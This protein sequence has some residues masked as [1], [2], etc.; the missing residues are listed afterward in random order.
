MMVGLPGSGKSYYAE[1]LA[2]SLNYCKGELVRV[3]SR[4]EIRF[5][6]LKDDEN[7]FKHET[8][9]FNKY[10][11][12]IQASLNSAAINAVIADATHLNET[13]RN[14]LLNRLDLTNIEVVP[15]FIDTPYKECLQRNATRQ[16]RAYVPQKAIR[17][18]SYSLTAP[19]YNEKHKYSNI[20]TIKE[21][22][23]L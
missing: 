2:D 19:T 14:K 16:G 10:V 21:G 5:S 13:S 22:E 23:V 15:I 3:V 6:M 1:K 12:V 4:D 9:V 8:E 20:I 18:M 11:E 7:Y 17:N